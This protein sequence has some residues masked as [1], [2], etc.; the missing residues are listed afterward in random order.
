MVSQ[1]CGKK[2]VEGYGVPIY[3]SV[4]KN[5]AISDN[6]EREEAEKKIEQMKRISKQIRVKEQNL[7]LGYKESEAL[8]TMNKTPNNT[9]PFYWY[10]GKKDGKIMLAPFARRNNVGVDT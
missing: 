8:V 1:E 6:Y 2:A 9:L 7:Y 4:I 5:K 10:E 3:A